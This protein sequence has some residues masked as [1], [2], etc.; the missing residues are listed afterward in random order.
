MAAPY[1]RSAQHHNIARMVLR[2]LKDFLVLRLFIRSDRKRYKSASSDT[3]A[4]FG[5]VDGKGCVK[6]AKFGF[7]HSGFVLKLWKLGRIH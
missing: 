7:I 6:V 4:A 3:T 1:A 5:G 2:Q